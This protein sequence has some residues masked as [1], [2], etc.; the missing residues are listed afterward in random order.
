MRK[1]EFTILAVFVLLSSVAQAR[2]RIAFTSMRDGNNEIYAMDT[3]GKNK[4]RLTNNKASDSAPA[5]SPN[6]QKIAFVSRRDNNNEIYIMDTDGSNQTRLTNNSGN[7]D[8]DKD[9]RPLES[10]PSKDAINY[11]KK[12]YKMVIKIKDELDISKVKR[13]LSSQEIEKKL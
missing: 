5:W 3:D 12:L 8:D 4:R 2:E 6:G 9:W 1:F 10:T 11:G 13:T 7:S